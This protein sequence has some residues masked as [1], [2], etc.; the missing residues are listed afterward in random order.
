VILLGVFAVIYLA[1]GVLAFG[2]LL[3]EA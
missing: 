2:A 1:L 3:E